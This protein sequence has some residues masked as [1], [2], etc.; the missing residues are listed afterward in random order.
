MHR[1]PSTEENQDITKFVFNLLPWAS[2]S[3]DK[4]QQIMKGGEKKSHL[5]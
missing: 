1:D 5:N 3:K 4:S 2:L